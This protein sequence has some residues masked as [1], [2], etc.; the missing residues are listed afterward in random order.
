MD[1]DVFSDKNNQ[2]FFDDNFVSYKV[3]AEKGNG[4][5]LSFLYAVKEYPTL[6]FLDTKG[7]V[8]QRKEGAAYHTELMN[9]AR[10]SIGLNPASQS[11]Q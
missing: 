6:L 3:D 10:K 11:T 8:L 2:N 9:L 1:S 4:P 5:N 7:R